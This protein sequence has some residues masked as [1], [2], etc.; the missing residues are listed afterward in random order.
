MDPEG[1][2]NS[3]FKGNSISQNEARIFIKSILKSL[4]INEVALYSDYLFKFLSIDG[5]RIEKDIFISFFNKFGGV[6]K[7]A[8]Y[9]MTDLSSCRGFYNSL[10]PPNDLR[11]CEYVIC[12]SL[13]DEVIAILYIKPDKM[14]HVVSIKYNKE[15]GFVS[16]KW[17]NEHKIHNI[18]IEKFISEILDSIKSKCRRGFLARS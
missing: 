5:A 6:S 8:I 7:E 16:D 9:A 3:K 12:K 18:D 4:K 2:W 1:L 14:I 13:G 11:L 17:K 10:I 15:K